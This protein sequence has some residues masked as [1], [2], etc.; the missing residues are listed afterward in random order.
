LP[1]IAVT[2]NELPIDE[3]V[4]PADAGEV[5]AAVAEAHAS[6]TALYPIGGGTSLDFGLPA[7]VPGK[8]L[9]LAAMRR[10]VDFP[11]GDMT[12]TVEAG[13][14]MAALDKVLSAEGQ[15]L[16]IDV[17]RAE[18]A[19]LG[20]V[21]ATNFNGPRRYGQGSIRDHVIGIGAVDGRG[22]AF[23]GGGRVV[24][25]VAGYDFC[26][27]LVGS[28][29]T[30]GVVTQVTLRLKPRPQRSV[31]V[32]CRPGDWDSA[33]RLLA[34]VAQ[35]RTA[36]TAVELLAGPAWSSDPDLAAL[37]EG[38]ASAGPYLVIGLEGTEPEVAYMIE[39]LAGEWRELGVFRH[40]VISDASAE[41]LWRRLAEFPSEGNS[42]LVLKAATR[43][44]AVTR[45]AQ[46]V[47]AIDGQSSIQAHAGSGVTIARLAEFPAG[48]LSRTLV[49]R[50]QPIAAAAQ[51]HV[52]ILSN[53]GG[54]EMTHQS[55]WGSRR[56]A[57]A[58]MAE[59]KRRFD[60]KNV[61]NP[62]RF[63]YP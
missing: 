31:L 18:T 12:I 10:V 38:A 54:A 47:I 19:T 28:L 9:S 52:V 25:N 27:L 42:P 56:S 13:I 5:A 4:A 7:R 58:L 29:G 1:A 39:R 35:S 33:E 34:G 44:S 20:G 6:G 16:P 15:R 26:K 60:P 22:R 49:G 2:P 24:K 57:F 37:G 41:G 45:F 43:A 61:L 63:V 3:I 40:H 17:P 50:L 48:G 14:T 46:E 30:L 21:A 36:P 11:A 8:G 23:K 62:G 59:V 53:P 51:G 32:A 55:V